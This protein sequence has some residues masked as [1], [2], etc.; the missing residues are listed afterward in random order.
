MN[1]FISVGMAIIIGVLLGK[2][3]NK[4]KI[5]AVAGYVIAGL[6]L[7]VSCLNLISGEMSEQLSF[8]GDFALGII[9]FNIGSELEYSV[10]KRLG[11]PIFIIAFFEAIFA[12][13]LVTLVTILLGEKI[14]TALILGAVASATAPAAT[15]MVLNELKAKGPLTSTLL[16]VVAVDDAICLM[17]YAI[18]SSLAKVFIKHTS[19][20]MYSL[21][22]L[23]IKEIV[24]SILSGFLLGILLVYI[25]NRLHKDSE[26]QIVAL[27][28]I[29]TLTGMAMKYN[30]SPLLSCMSLG[31]AVS[32]LCAHSNEVFSTIEKFDS[33]IITAFF[34][35]AG[36]RLNISLI[37]KIGLL[38]ICYLIFRIIGKVSGAYI[39]GIISKAPKVVKKYIGYGLFSQIGVAIGLAIIV[40]REF[41]GTGLDVKVLTILLATTIITEIIGPISTKQA[42]I[43]AK[44]AN[45]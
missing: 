11:K 31:I 6:V 8:I 36:A 29:I 34:V 2:I 13:I 12:F 1:P 7:G 43:K 45:I 14:Y 17:I 20:N 16:G 23:P 18:A 3:M 25:I 22:Y 44:E 32:N 15:V 4:F 35:L 41:K 21:I 40:S 19:I 27:G 24:L 28:F 30:L 5:P 10:L 37:P 9:A 26:I 42:I 38:G 39:G 33:P